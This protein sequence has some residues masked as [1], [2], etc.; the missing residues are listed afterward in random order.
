MELAQLTENHVDEF[1]FD[2]EGNTSIARR[3]ES[4]FE[5]KFDGTESWRKQLERT[6]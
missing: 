6:P 2:T 3:K 5:E 1:C 4:E